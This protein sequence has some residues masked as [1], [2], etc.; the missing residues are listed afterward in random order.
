MSA[1]AVL[2]A[3][4]VLRP[5]SRAYRYSL[6][7]CAAFTLLHMLSLPV[8]VT[9]DGHLYVDLADVIGSR[10]FPGDWDLLRTP[11]YPLVLKLAF[12]LLGKQPLAVIAVGSLL[13]FVGIWALGAATK[14]MGYPRAAAAGVIAATLYP[15]LVVYEH[16]LLTEAGTFCFVALLVRLLVWNAEQMPVHLKAAALGSL[17]V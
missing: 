4:A 6:Y 14:E 8:L 5:S 3:V 10:R 16:S 12:W 7:F 15:T 17:L 11:L 13:G 2:R 1:R 9:Y